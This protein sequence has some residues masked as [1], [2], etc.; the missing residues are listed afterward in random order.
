MKCKH[1][2]GDGYGYD[3]KNETLN[4]CDNCNILLAEQIMKQ[5]ATEVFIGSILEKKN[6]RS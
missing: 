2:T 1:Y 4:L 6:L 3:L 5:I